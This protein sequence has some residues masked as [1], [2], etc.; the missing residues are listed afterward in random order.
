MVINNLLLP[1]PDVLLLLVCGHAPEELLAA[2][3]T[4]LELVVLPA[5][6][7]LFQRVLRRVG[8]AEEPAGEGALPVMDVAAQPN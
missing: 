2:V 8:D 4:V 1:L 7:V 6:A 3:G 5:E